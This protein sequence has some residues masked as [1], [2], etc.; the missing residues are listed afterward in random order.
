[1][2]R[3]IKFGIG[4]ALAVMV[5]WV[6][7]SRGGDQA[8]GSGDFIL[9]KSGEH[10]SLEAQGAALSDVL[11]KLNELSGLSLAVDPNLG[12]TVTA[13]LKDVELEQVLAAVSRSRAL[14][15]EEQADKTYKLVEARLTSQQ[16]EIEQPVAVAKPEPG[17]DLLSPGVLTNTKK[18]VGELRARGGKAILLQNAVIDTEAARNGDKLAVPTAFA[19]P[20][21]AEHQ[22]VQ[23]D[24]AVSDSELNQLKG[25]G[26]EI[27][28]YVPN[29][30]YAVRVTP[31]QLAALQKLPGVTHIEPYHPYFKMSRDIL[32]ALTG[33]DDE[34]AVTRV[35]AGAFNALS[36]RGDRVSDALSAAGAEVTSS[37]TVDGRE[38]VTFRVDA[39]KLPEVLALSNVQWV[40]PDV[41][42]TAMNDL[43]R[44]RVRAGSLRQ[45]HPTLTGQGVTIGLT[46]SGIDFQHMTFS[47]DPMGPPTSTNLN[48][49]I[50]AY[51]TRAGGPTADGIPGDNN[52][53]GTHVA[54]T[55]LGNGALSTN[56]IKAP[57]SGTAP[58]G[59]NQFAGVAPAA[60]VVVIED[61]N[62]YSDTE[63]AELTVSAGARIS[64]NSWGNS[65]YEYGTLSAIWDALVLDAN[66]NASGKQPL[67]AFFAAGN[68]GGGDNDG[69]G[70]TPGTIGQ[71]GNAKNVIT[72]GALEQRRKAQNLPNASPET[73]S[74]W[75]IA[76][77]SSRGPVTGS[78]PRAKPDLVAPG[79]YVLSAQ[80]R[81]TM[82]DELIDPFSPNRDY[83][84]DNLNSGTNY[85]FFS[86]TSMATPVAAGAG[87]LFF[88][89]YTNAF[90]VEPSPALM[91]AAL[92]AGA[93][94]VNSLVYSLPR[95]NSVS[96]TVDQGFGV[97]DVK[98]SVDG[99][100][101][102]STDFIE[103]F[104]ESAT[105]P[106]GTDDIYTHQV[107]LGAGEGGLK[108][109]LVWSDPAGTPGN[110]AQLVN[111]L[112]LVVLPPGGGGYLGNQL[113]Y[114]GVNAKKFESPDPSTYGDGY[115]NVESVVI[116]DAPLGSYTIQVRGYQ[117]A[118]ADKQPFALVVMKGIG[119][120]GK[121][122]GDSV[123]M[124]LDTNSR[125]VIAYSASDAAG[126]KQIFVKRWVGGFGDFSELGNWWRM[127]DQWAGYRHS[128]VKT[129]ISRTL[130]DSEEPSIA[131]DGENVFVAWRERPRDFGGTNVSRIFVRQ[132]DGAD[133]IQ[134][135]GSAQ[136]FGVPNSASYNTF[137][138]QIAVMG[139]GQPVV[140]WLQYSDASTNLVHPRVAVWDGMN[141]VGLAN[142]HSNGLAMSAT[143]SANVA[144][145]LS[146][147]INKQGN[148]VVAWK[149]ARINNSISVRQWNGAVW[150]SLNYSNSLFFIHE[151]RITA[152]R[153]SDDLYL[154]WRQQVSSPLP[155]A[156]EQIFAAKRTGGSWTQMAGSS[157]HPGISALTNG[158][159]ALYPY[160]PSIT[161]GEVE[162][163]TNVF[164]SW[165]AGNSNGNFVLVRQWR[166]GQPSWSSSYGAGTQPGIDIWPEQAG[167]PISAAD[168]YGLPFVSFPLVDG[169]NSAIATY[170]VISDRSPPTFAGL[171][172]AVGGTNA[173][174]ALT[175]LPAVDDLSTTI[176]YRIYRSTAG[177]AC[178]MP[179]VCD[180][181]NVFGNLIATVTNIT[182]FTVTG[183]TPNQ[184]YCFGVRAMDT[185][186]LV[187]A[188]TVMRS[189]GPVSGTGDND[190]DC[191][192]NAIEIAAGTEPCVQDTDGDGMRDGWEWAFSTNNLS[193]T[194]PVSIW[195]T[196][197]FVYLSPIDNGVDN[198]RTSALNDGDPINLPEADPDGDGAS[199]YE[200]FLWWLNN[201]AS[202]AITNVSIPAGPNP[203]AWDTDL[204][205]M[206]DGW[207]MINGLNPIDPSDASGDLD[208][209][210]LTN[211][212]EY[213]YGTDPNNPDSD[214]DGL[215]DG[216]E[217]NTHK[218]N[219]A[220]ADS[221][222][223]GLDDG[224]EIAIGTN[225]TRA[226][227]DANF[228]SDG[229][230]VQLD[231]NPLSGT[232]AF[233]NLMFESF[234]ATSG[235]RS[236]WTHYA[237]SGSPLFDLWHLSTAEPAPS[238]G[239]IA[240]AYFGA[241]TTSTAYRA[242][243][244]PTGTNVDARYNLGMPLAMALQSP[245]FTNQA[246]TVS[247][248]FV[249]WAEYYET[250]PSFDQT[251]VQV[252]SLPD[253]NW[254]NVSQ[255]MSGLSGVTNIN[256]TNQSAR[257]VYRIADASAFAG[258]SN[259]QVRF[260]FS[261][262]NAIN[263]DYRGWWV[264][265]VRV[266]EGTSIK[267]WV[268]D[269][270][271]R[272]V[273]GATV[274]ALGKGGVTNRVDGHRYVLP[275]KVFGE[276]KTAADG[277][278]TIPGLPAGNF[279]VKAAAEGYIAEFYDG[280][281][282]TNQY[283][284]GNGHRPGVVNRESVSASG[285]VSLLSLGSQTNVHFELGLGKG[286]PR[287]GVVLPN[288]GSLAYPIFVDGRP[289]TYWNGSVGAPALLPY[290]SSPTV[291][292]QPNF[293]DWLTNAVAP[294]Y[295]TTLTPGSYT[296]V[297]GTNLPLYPR[298]SVD[299]REGE[300]TKIILATNQAMSRIAVSTASNRAY[301][302]S[303][304]GRVL[305]NQS[306]T[307]VNV[308][309][310]PHEVSLVSTSTLARISSKSV[311]API[312][313]RVQVQFT[314]SELVGPNGVLRIEA[315]DQFGRSLSNVSVLVNG[316][317]ISTNE[318]VG[319]T[320]N[321]PALDITS[322]RPGD[323]VIAVEKPGYRASDRRVV[324]VFSGVTNSTKFVLYEADADF[325]RVGDA[326]EI[327]GYTNIFTYHRNDDPDGDGLSN[328][329]EF[330]LFRNFGIRL[331]I[332]DADTDKDGVTDGQEVGYD[333][334]TNRFAFSTLYTNALQGAPQ[335]QSRFVGEYLA[336]V[337]NFGSGAGRVVS[338][339]GDRFVGDIY[340]PLLAVPTKEPA[341]TVFTNIATFPSNTAVSVAHVVNAAIF[342][343]LM[344]HIRD[345]DGDEMWDG[346]EYVYRL[347][348]GPMD[349]LDNSDAQR[350]SDFDGLSNLNEFLGVDHL[351]NTNDWTDPGRADSD[352]DFMPD[353]WEY[354]YG[355][356][357]LNPS[358]A[359]TD[360]D[361]DGLINLAEFLAGTSPVLRDTDSDYLGDYEEV[362]IY[363]TDPN[364]PDTDGDGLL[365]GREVWDKDMDGIRD[366]GFFPMWDGGDLD[367]DG[368]VDGPTDWDTDGDGMPDGFEVLDSDGNIRP[369]NATLNPYDPTDGDEDADG[370]GLSNLEEYLVRDA[371][372]GNHPSGY[373]RFDSAWNRGVPL[374]WLF[375]ERPFAYQQPVWDYSTDPFSADS[376]GDGMPDGFEVQGG[377]H[378][379]DPLPSE[380]GSDLLRYPLLGN[381]GDPD[382]DGLWNELEYKIRFQLDGSFSTNSIL[383]KATHPW[384]TDTDGDGVADGFE[385]HALF[386]NPTEQDSDGD[387]LM[388]GV[389]VPGKWGEI[390]SQRK[391]DYAIYSCPTCT[392]ET[393]SAIASSTPHPSDP[394]VF[395][396]LAVVSDY[397][398]L[399]RVQALLTGAETNVALGMLDA[400]GIGFYQ[401][402]SGEPFVYQYFADDEPQVISGDVNVVYMR[403]DGY[404]G[405][406]DTNALM[407]HFIVEW[408][409]DL[410][411]NHY[412]QAMNDLWELVWPL[413]DSPSRPYWQ[414]VIPK[415]SSPLPPARWGAAAT[416]S[417]VFERKARA[418]D[419]G[420]VGRY[421]PIAIPVLDGRKLIVLGGV[422]G[423]DR[424]T[425][426][427]E[428]N[429]R[430]NEWRR[431]AESFLTPANA[432][433]RIQDMYA[434]LSDFSA[435]LLHGYRN[436][437]SSSLRGLYDNTDGITR[438]GEDF[439]EPKDRPWNYGFKESS[440]DMTYI[441]GGWNSRNKYM[442]PEPMLTVWYKS[443]DDRDVINELNDANDHQVAFSFEYAATTPSGTTYGT[444]GYRSFSTTDKQI[445]IGEVVR[446]YTADDLVV[447]L[448]S[449]VA[450]IRFEKFPFLNAGDEIVYAGLRLD[451]NS[452]PAAT[453]VF[454]VVGEFNL[455]DRSSKPYE[456]GNS[457]APTVPDTQDAGADHPSTR[458]G[459]AVNSTPLDVVFTNY[460]DTDGYGVVT[461][462]ASS[463]ILELDVTPIVQELIADPNW[464][465]QA[466]GF[467]IGETNGVADSATVRADS[468][469]NRIRVEWIPAYKQPPRWGVGSRVQ[470]E[471]TAGI[472]SQRKSF[473]MVYAHNQNQLL[474][475][476][477]MDGRQVF[478]DTFQAQLRGG[479]DDGGDDTEPEALEPGDP[480]KGSLISFVPWQKVPTEISPSPRWG[481]SMV[482]DETHGD[483]LLFGG[484]DANNQP[485]NDLWVY[486]FSF[487]TTNYIADTNGVTNAVEE[488]HSGG[489]Q[490]ITVLLDGQK[491]SPRG[492]AMFAYFGGDVYH[493]GQT[494]DLYSSTRRDRFVLF[495]G[496]DGK[497]Y[498]N[499]TW[500]FYR[501]YQSYILNQVTSDRW[502]LVDPGGEQSRGPSPR[503]FGSM[504][505]A[506]NGLK[507]PDP[508]GEGSYRFNG[509]TRNA[510]QATV[511]LFGGRTG[512][513]P[514]GTDTDRDLVPDGQEHELGGTAAGRDPR[515]NALV[516]PDVGGIET[517]PYN[518]KRLGAWQG[519]M[520]W[521]QRS[522]IADLEALSYDERNEAWRTGLFTWQGWPIETTFTNESYVVGD[523]TV[524][525][526]E[527]P[528][529]DRLVFITG[530]DALAPDWTNMWYHRYP[531]GYGDPRD[532]RD[533][534][535]LGIPAPSVSA[536]NSAPPYAY[537]GRWVYGTK[538]SG[539]YPR[540]AIMEL[541]SPIFDTRAPD[542]DSPHPDNTNPYFLMFHE[543]L[544]LADSN[545]VVR[546]DIVRPGSPADV[547]TRVSGL[548]RP[549]IS[550]IPNRNNSA[551]TQGK[552]RRVIVPL[553]VVG[554]DSNLYARFTLQSDTNTSV[555]GG[556]YIDDI[557]VIQGAEIS[558][559]LA[560]GTNTEVC[561]IGENFNDN[562]LDCTLSETNGLFQF[563]LL[564][565]GNYQVVS[566]GATNGPYI[567][568]NSTLDIDLSVIA[569]EFTDISP[570]P[571]YTAAIITWSATNGAAYQ[572]DYTTNLITGPWT[573]LYSVT[574]GVNT[575]LSYTDLFSSVDRIYRVS[576]TNAP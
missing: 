274:R 339:E 459:T 177:V 559:L 6:G 10:Y 441:L 132:W 394:S 463:S 109:V 238:T 370:D 416:Y 263:N 95:A 365:D 440:Y 248:L 233:N 46:D 465:G 17:S 201:G 276:V 462:N 151:P 295:L 511:L 414:Q 418:F 315:E 16:K 285:I 553:N 4:S 302:I 171:Q 141:W 164:V 22:I 98:R 554:N 251:V 170:T 213:H 226:D 179:I 111:D 551:N 13:S 442:L 290:Q 255:V 72:I 456:G 218:T 512:T 67:V 324:S 68:S 409:I 257:W 256:M 133:W 214:G 536:S 196:N 281:L 219:P 433:Y 216:A 336:G 346:F 41:R 397:D 273:Q 194:N 494:L 320:F 27:T 334:N 469:D 186:G 65:V 562:V 191:L 470:A 540:D 178:G 80:S 189:A 496:T 227:T 230:A 103:Y 378:P 25:L 114:D 286:V 136:D 428:F 291:G 48:T 426:I 261:I 565:L 380:N 556:W 492:G 86:G 37:Q 129:G 482:Y 487:V 150:Q 337:D 243:F 173:N 530:V 402:V 498:F 387:R 425:D 121:T 573:F 364:N 11:A 521:L 531:V 162:G 372:F 157:T 265:D 377:L 221:D 519:H 90:G 210:G 367:G 383:G 211:L 321:A 242:A 203:T 54:G 112:D 300:S 289:L 193:K 407:D 93:R 168:R 574:S 481:H 130:E 247:N 449:T 549:T 475:F 439:G 167:A 271:G 288:A 344:P 158:M 70:G 539:F 74:D 35:N 343:D 568:A 119:I 195:N 458:W 480:S 510:A 220:R 356:N 476:G 359:Y 509:I 292:L 235:T 547:Y 88:Q 466:I 417:P 340:H 31:E 411:T 181:T 118:S 56:V 464:R 488:A 96:T 374:G 389:A 506:Q 258:R 391:T 446:T 403:P 78:D 139:S 351:A 75:Q 368:L 445:P 104:D 172:S 471:N 373:P 330:E 400:I 296:L 182:S 188:N 147:T 215:T 212:D 398:E 83:R 333:G 306:P 436:T 541:Y 557:A 1:M 2:N 28:H 87:A 457:G 217:V 491:P 307:V 237:L 552:W 461:P 267:G 36:F 357:P 106:I 505:Y 304:D 515:V 508:H 381:Y 513:L 21:D 545:D 169:A 366:G 542:P 314:N 328:L 138:P 388:D 76:Y 253:T 81:D 209:D 325:D 575:T 287:L 18:P 429:I 180:E 124:A 362:M 293:P 91:K 454:T 338:I 143:N 26:I 5:A 29:S 558:G 399:E 468:N 15:Y 352:N 299:L 497:D 527:T 113:D 301:L 483:V 518:L 570:G 422:D 335:V 125:P 341:L 198:I 166:S 569:P 567:L 571:G 97:I 278:F 305:T 451:V 297:A 347:P 19:A 424:Y 43:A 63:Q 369:P 502:T 431:S 266:Y 165:R 79:S 563:G 89:Y 115:N 371:L 350:D 311:I 268:R 62:S 501:D 473:A 149:E 525:P 560:A 239:G 275:G 240:I 528:N 259:V 184:I 245:T 154:A 361:G 420:N 252:R 450:G 254:V 176:Y 120:E 448:T 385:H 478:G 152:A 544:D 23:F 161:V 272:A 555:A 332:L 116:S 550:L 60:K 105:S 262:K 101:Y 421:D 92:V 517:V 12:M 467:L 548:D 159:N 57:G 452:K 127:E 185:N 49:R 137:S 566:A 298:V 386:G 392:W 123:A 190:G 375:P 396:H 353:G 163:M 128:A 316:S 331:N 50:A 8:S 30:A 432:S 479:A 327:E 222:G 33:A 199:N 224:Y 34:Q 153:Q 349:P 438:S 280:L 427:W 84:Y 32:S 270:N 434:G 20:A 534:W 66:T 183:L 393:A 546:V 490:E 77:Y 24:H 329:Q 460:V 3:F 146:L 444:G 485:L 100:S 419:G 236:A 282:F 382:E 401:T 384:I 358:D 294:T 322:L 493:S 208:G 207:E 283:A 576:I 390:N 94:T 313:S 437:L 507:R 538:L 412:D 410:A 229:D 323:H 495:G 484:F 45:L 145:S 405:V 69:T 14:V 277:S 523:E 55:I 206:P 64:N 309:A 148:P 443:T 85:A 342:A 202:C 155:Y 447:V 524:I 174:V 225:P 204:D 514:A 197:T 535:E 59:T 500:V 135:N 360:L 486:T 303:I 455:V 423:V 200:E 73:D 241:R 108:I 312:G 117:V 408:N 51:Y 520:S 228:L 354:Q 543:W 503:A 250:E 140:A 102:R 71:P 7:I 564:P 474:L 522:H 284:F 175:W 561:L 355:L 529:P 144:S 318:L 308:L 187:D 348:A 477:G 107:T 537:S 58:Y 134:L 52:G 532:P 232:P 192:P 269:V 260:L 39:K 430:S 44:Q 131:V 279:Y 142:S 42:P 160:E 413:A 231:L 110:A 234:E 533:V 504:V 9:T 126:Q 317:A 61:F 526:F 326:L 435:V 572:L 205:G 38:R 499:D 404:W 244:D 246:T 40:E 363:G 319:K 82:P 415:P 310:G 47:D 156:A 264:D 249:A 99:P 395:G 53:H 516:N 379:M 345:T 489:W 223:D 453:T 122:E 376:D 406:T 472:P